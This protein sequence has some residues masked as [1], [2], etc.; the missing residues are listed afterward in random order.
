MGARKWTPEQRA[1]QSAAIQRWK[2]WATT[3]GPK[4]PEGKAKVGQNAFRGGPRATLKA[5]RHLAR[6]VAADAAWLRSL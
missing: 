5:M 3:T 6:L 1:K 4:T 2:P